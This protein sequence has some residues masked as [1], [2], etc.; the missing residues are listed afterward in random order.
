MTLY[1]TEIRTDATK[2]IATRCNV[3][4][5]D[6]LCSKLVSFII[7][8]RFHQLENTLAYYQICT[9]LIIDVLFYRPL[10]ICSVLFYIAS[11][12]GP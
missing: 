1:K 12:R 10:E 4:N 9:L 5:M 8:S 2:T 11:Y 6:R 7:A 3:Q